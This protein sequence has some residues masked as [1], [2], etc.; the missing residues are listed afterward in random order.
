MDCWTCA[1]RLNVVHKHSADQLMMINT[2]NLIRFTPMKR[3]SIIITWKEA[4]EDVDHWYYHSVKAM[5]K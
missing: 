3:S 4:V 5:R 2:L 1:N